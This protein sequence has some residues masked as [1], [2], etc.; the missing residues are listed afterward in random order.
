MAAIQAL[1]TRAIWLDH[2]AV[3][4]D[5]TV[6][7]CL[8]RYLSHASTAPE[9]GGDCRVALGPSLELQAFEFGPNPVETGG[10]AEFSMRIAATESSRIEHLAVLIYSLQETRIAIVDLR[11]AGAPKTL[12][13]GES[14]SLSGWIAAFPLVEGDYRVGLGIGASTFAG[15][16]L[17]LVDLRVAP[18]PDTSGYVPY[19]AAYRG[20][21]E[22]EFG[23]HG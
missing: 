19:A 6:D 5:G 13:A 15:D 20:V 16:R 14:W 11:R 12:R 10:R 9:P 22:L 18:K 1:C 17:G 21:V 2:G 8:S 23:V 7:E 3:A 4:V